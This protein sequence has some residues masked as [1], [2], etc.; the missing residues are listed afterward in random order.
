VPVW[1]G[2]PYDFC[3]SQD[4]ICG[5]GSGKSLKESDLFAKS[6]IASFFRLQL[7][8]S[9]ESMMQ[10]KSIESEKTIEAEQKETFHQVLSSQVSELVEGVEIIQRYIL[11]EKEY[12]SLARLKKN[13][14][15]DKLRAEIKDFNVERSNLL[16]HKARLSIYPM[17]NLLLQRQGVEKLLS[18]LDRPLIGHQKS[19][20]WWEETTQMLNPSRSVYVQ[21]DEE[22]KDQEWQNLL[23][24]AITGAGHKVS[25][26][27]NA[28][29]IVKSTFKM[30]MEPINVDGFLKARIEW[31]ASSL[32][33]E[34]GSEVL[35]A[36]DESIDVTA[37]NKEQ[38]WHRA[39]D[40]FKT[41]VLEKIH[42][43]NI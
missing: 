23:L 9:L 37:R 11:N 7:N 20:P 43:L 26:S 14:L 24:S 3:K 41:K 31:K 27:S 32:D 28:R 18:M 4:E 25:T 33:H 29:Y 38:L 5:V 19:G 17:K 39:K 16:S 40:H 12:F 6:E 22:Q 30:N 15:E 21:F 2:A 36:L 34:R 1:I 8:S 35:G 10:G 13:T 42:L